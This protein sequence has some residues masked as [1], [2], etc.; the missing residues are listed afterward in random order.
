LVLDDGWDLEDG[1]ILTGAVVVV[2]AVVGTVALVD[3]IVEDLGSDALKREM[4][5]VDAEGVLSSHEAVAIGEEMTGGSS[6]SDMVTGTSS[7]G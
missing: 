2:A 1:E 5:G 3:G 6:S 4:A 7:D